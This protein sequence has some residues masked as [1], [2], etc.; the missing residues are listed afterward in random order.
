MND[1]YAHQE[2]ELRA[3]AAEHLKTDID[4][5]YL[6]SIKLYPSCVV[7]YDAQELGGVCNQLCIGGILHRTWQ[8]D[9]H[10]CH[11]E[12]L[13][14]TV[15][16]HTNIIQYSI[17]DIIEAFCDSRDTDEW[18]GCPYVKHYWGDRYN[19]DEWDCPGE[20]CPADNNCPYHDTFIEDVVDGLKDLG[21]ET[22]LEDW[23]V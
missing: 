5:Y 11:P 18:N 17:C 8:W 20:F 13:L 2:D 19:P 22:S 16:L 14:F 10:V 23:Y 3:I 21:I 12:Y 4:N 7:E 6:L 9:K 1:Y 15:Q